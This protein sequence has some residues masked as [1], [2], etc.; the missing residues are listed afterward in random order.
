MSR[1]SHGLFRTA[2]PNGFAAGAHHRCAS[3][4]ADLGLGLGEGQSEGNGH[5]SE[6]SFR[7][8]EQIEQVLVLRLQTHLA[9]H[10]WRKFKHFLM[11][12]AFSWGTIGNSTCF[13]SPQWLYIC[14]DTAD[15]L[16]VT[17][18]HCR[19]ASSIQCV[20]FVIHPLML[21]FWGCNQTNSH[22]FRFFC[23]C[24]SKGRA[25]WHRWI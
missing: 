21:D 8:V 20:I 9:L 19:F 16:F 5:G 1:C 2:F 22:V 11:F 13:I 7:S 14:R 17:F 18:Y 25:S 4:A 12:F 6:A 24:D 3:A 23:V 10:S 15:R